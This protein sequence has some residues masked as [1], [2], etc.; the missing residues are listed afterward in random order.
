VRSPSRTRPCCLAQDDHVGLAQPAGDRGVVG[1]APA[2]QDLRAA[3]GRDAPGVNTSLSAS[4]TPA[5]GPSA[6]PRARL[7]STAAAAV[8]APSSV[9]VQEGVHLLVH[10]GDPVQMRLGDFE[11][12][13]SPAA[14]DAASAAAVRRV[15]SVS[16]TC[17]SSPRILR[18]RKR[19]SSARGPGRAPR[20]GPAP[21]V[22]P[23]AHVLAEDVGQRE[24][25]R[26][27]RHVLGRQLADPGDGRRRMAS[28]WPAKWSSRRR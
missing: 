24:R 14:M 4:G 9:Y 2:L 17:Q 26:G 23:G 13:S 11:A 20:R 18:T 15:R 1:R 19:S 8:S 27:R 3:G 16:D 5:S 28:S 22:P 21:G 7:A 10:L 25:V 12:D 6:S